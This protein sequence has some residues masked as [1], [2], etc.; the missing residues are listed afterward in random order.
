MNRIAQFAVKYPVT[1]LM[2]VLGVVLLGYISFG[3]LGTDLFPD[4]NNPKIYI[5]LKAGERPPEEIEKNYVDQIESLAMRQS[6]VIEVSSVS[7]AGL[8][9]I[10]VEYD[11]NKDMDE[12][13]L[14]L[15]KELNSFSQN[16]D[17][18]DFTISQYDPNA[19]PVMTIALKNENIINMDDL[20]KTAENYIRNEL[21]RIE[22]VADVK[23]TGTDESEVVIETNR[24]LL[25]SFGLTTE[26]IAAQ[27]SNYNRNVSGGSIVDM[28]LKY[29]VKGVS[30]L[31]DIEDL[32][33]IIV[34]F[35]ETST[36]GS[37]SGISSSQPALSSRV[38]VYLKDIATI[39]FANKDP[40][41][42]VTLNGERCIGLSIYKEPK[43]IT[44]DV[45]KSL[46]KAITDLEK[47]LPGYKFVKVHDQGNYINKAIGEVKNTLIIGILL[48][49]VILYVFLRRI[50]ATLVISIAIPISIIATFNLMYFNHLT[51]N[52][53]TLG[54]LA[55]GAGMLVDNAIV[56]LEN[57]SRLREEGVPFV[58][59]VTRGTGEVGAAI[60][61]ST[62]T[63]IVV[64][65]PIVYLHGA[66]GEM[67][68][69]QAWTVAFSLLSSLVVAM[70]VIPMLVSVLFPDKNKN[71]KTP[72]VFKFNWYGRFL[73]A[74][75]VK[76]ITVII[77]SVIIMTG[78][79]LLIPHLGSEFMPRSES[80]EFTVNIKL[81]EGTGLQLT[82][83][84]TAS[85]ENIIKEMLGDK[86]RMIYSQAGSDK[87]SSF[88]QAGQSRGENTSS[89]K[90]IM[91]DESASIT[92]EAIS[93]I[94]KWLKTI[95]D[96]EAGFT[97]EETALQSSLGTSKAPFVLEISG[98]DYSELERIINECRVILETNTGLYNIT[99]SIDE[100]TPEVEVSVDRF[101]TSYYGVT[102]E[103]II[104]QVKGYLSGSSAGSFEKEG[105]MK[106]ITIRLGDLS[107]L[108]L[109]DMMIN[110]GAIKVPLSDIADIRTVISPR[111]ITR[112]NQARTCYIYAMVK[113]GSPLD[114]VV[115]EAE[116]SL[117]SI[118]LPVDYKIEFTGEELKRKESVSDLSFA[119]M[120]SLILVFMVLAAQFESVIQPFVIMLTI[121]LAGAG[122]VLI[123]FLLG[124]PMNMMAYIGIIMLGGIAVNNSILLIDRINRLRESGIPK[125]DAII[126]AGTQRIRPILMTSLT[127][128]LALL[129]LTIGLGESASLRSPMA[130]AVIGGLVSST[131]LT[132][133]LIPC[134]YW[135][136]DSF[137]KWFTGT[138]NFKEDAGRVS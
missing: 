60:T 127:T 28:G 34:G 13:F 113:S 52:I 98:D 33:N 108:S 61:S 76:R 38:P 85:T 65:L 120:L 42:I 24:Y 138:G 79:A 103:S 66:S 64:F 115:S 47:V 16:S 73:E 125:K 137:S 96:M 128:I 50:G 36:T 114:K 5:E 94:E 134:V 17:I 121:P 136:F 11:W 112:R 131:L 83:R 90:V 12:A 39:G 18:E 55:L 119:L 107:I 135:V 8:A 21:V 74:V 25:E 78:S 105:E 110:A 70:L 1:V 32:G 95:P 26:G 69:D 130:L 19:V 68:K 37:L 86:V 129:P 9:T 67:F 116:S 10:T 101:K 122:S 99:T 51:L 53:M 102:V 62:I 22:G 77:V 31:E 84:T 27:I 93:S 133:I 124:K 118:S 111:E 45:V 89:I 80:P 4:L 57:I 56:V 123:F 106:D 72:P 44:V 91:G 81:P 87:N 75:I 100:G 54:G 71:T 23:L 126:L 6:D 7:Q 92:G 20:R 43:F 132:L 29:I 109:S 41:N 117:K 14:D 2:L 58:E 49:V 35:K 104:N 30:V 59:S 3:K 46:D 40:E 88:S 97:R 63:T 48:A 82:E 15:Q